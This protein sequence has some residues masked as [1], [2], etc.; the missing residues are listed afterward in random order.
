M[1]ANARNGLAISNGQ[2]VN[3]CQT[4][5]KQLLVLNLMPTKVTTELQFLKQFDQLGADV[6]L[7]FL[8]P[9]SHR[10]KGTP[11]NVISCHY[12][13]LAQI[14]HSTFAG[15]IVTGAP[16]EKLNFTQVDYWQ[17]FRQ[18]LAWSQS[19]V[20]ETLFECWAAQAGLFVDFTIPKRLLP[21]KLFG[22]YTANRIDHLSGL[23]EG[24]GAGGVV[25]MPQSRHSTSII[26]RHRLPGD[27]QIIADSKEAGPLILRSNRLH[28]TYI[29]GHP[30]YSRDTLAKEYYRDQRKHQ[31]IHPP[32]HYFQN[33]ATGEVNY[34]WQP[35]SHSLY[36]NWLNTLT[37]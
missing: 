8:Y 24:L 37:N 5:A 32:R 26:D 7:T 11:A 2:W 34:S 28:H 30:E 18:I 20:H 13:S 36:Q 19:H 12:A 29:T 35:T 3:H 23:T 1:T 31:A 6:E 27:L 9:T 33:E 22:I 15:L 14:R 21:S 25:K 10:F 4:V 16:V 17:E